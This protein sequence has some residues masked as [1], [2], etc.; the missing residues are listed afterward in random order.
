MKLGMACLMLVMCVGCKSGVSPKPIEQRIG[1]DEEVCINLTGE[2]GVPSGGT[3]PVDIDGIDATGSASGTDVTGTRTTVWVDGNQ[4]GQVDPGE[5]FIQGE[6]GNGVSAPP[7]VGTG[8]PPPPSP[9]PGTIH[10]PH[11]GHPG[12][13]KIRIKVQIEY[14]PPGG[15]N[16]KTGEIDDEIGRKYP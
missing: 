1:C 11:P 2:W 6:T 10:V 4:N 12:T 13:A 7:P 5:P 16:P 15:G 8:G 9:I 3:I 14:E